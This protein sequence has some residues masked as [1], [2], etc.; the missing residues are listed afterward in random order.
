MVSWEL[1]PKSIPELQQVMHKWED[2][3]S[4]IVEYK[5]EGRRLF[6]KGKKK[7]MPSPGDYE[8]VQGEPPWS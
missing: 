4:A 2:F 6:P 8:A 7:Y 5:Q 3:F 1:P